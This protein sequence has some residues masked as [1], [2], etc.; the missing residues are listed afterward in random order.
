MGHLRP[1][2]RALH[3]DVFLGVTTEAVKRFYI[4]AIKR[5]DIEDL[6]VIS[7]I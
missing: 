3:G 1:Q 7:V 4:R 2:P 6:G 5:A